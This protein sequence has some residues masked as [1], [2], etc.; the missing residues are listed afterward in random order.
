MMMHDA[1]QGY[2]WLGDVS[3]HTPYDF[4]YTWVMQV[5]ILNAIQLSHG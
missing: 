1:R 5:S 2:N 3:Q 4:K